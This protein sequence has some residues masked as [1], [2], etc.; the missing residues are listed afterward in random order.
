MDV[1]RKIYRAILEDGTERVVEVDRI[2]DGYYLARADGWFGHMASNTARSAAAKVAT[3]P[4]SRGAHPFGWPVVEILAPGERSRAELL[5]EIAS[6]QR[7]IDAAQP[8]LQLE[9]IR[10]GR[11]RCEGCGLIVVGGHLACGCCPKCCTC[12]APEAPHG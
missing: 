4:T 12:F 6:L 8:A 10:A 1:H 2:E 5:A 9:A 7:V 11:M 3:H